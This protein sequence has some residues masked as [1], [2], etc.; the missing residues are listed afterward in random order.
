MEHEHGHVAETAFIEG[1]RAASDKQAFLT[2][3]RIPL[4]LAASDGLGLKLV[5]V[6]LEDTV[7]VGRASRGFASKELVYQPLPARLVTTETR[8]RFRYISAEAVREL[9]LAEVMAAT[10]HGHAHPAEDATDSPEF[11][12]IG[13]HG[14]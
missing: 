10:S 4:E 7:E 11:C 2:L 6:L 1:F 13:R 14:T 3:A 12:R 9:S 5:Q 8:L